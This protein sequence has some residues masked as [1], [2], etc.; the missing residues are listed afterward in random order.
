MH[1]EMCV[2]LFMYRA[3]FPNSLSFLA[4]EKSTL[5]LATRAIA[6]WLLKNLHIKQNCML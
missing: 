4:G 2:C 6:G 3:V 1:A 5:P